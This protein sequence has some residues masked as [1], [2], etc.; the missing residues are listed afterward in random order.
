MM[1]LKFIK[2][3]FYV[4][5]YKEIEDEIAIDDSFEISNDKAT[6]DLECQST[7]GIVL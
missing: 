4:L 5:T 2:I 3:P 6:L 7:C 1:M